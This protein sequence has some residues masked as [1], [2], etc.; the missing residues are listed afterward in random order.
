MIRQFINNLNGNNPYGITVNLPAQ[1]AG[2][3]DANWNAAIQGI[4]ITNSQQ[5]VELDVP[6]T[7]TDSKR[8]FLTKAWG[9]NG[10]FDQ[11]NWDHASGGDILFSR[12]EGKTLY[13]DNNTINEYT[14]ANKMQQIIDFLRNI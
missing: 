5:Q 10:L 12:E 13:L 8:R 3:D 2:Y 7:P 4:T 9:L 1:I 11:Y 6:K 14:L